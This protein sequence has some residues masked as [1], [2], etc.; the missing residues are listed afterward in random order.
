MK[1][2]DIIRDEMIKKNSH[3]SQDRRRN[4]RIPLRLPLI[5]EGVN[6]E[7]LP[8]REET[9]TENVSVSGACIRTKQRLG[10]GSQLKISAVK[11]PFRSKAVVRTIWADEI[12][13]VM[14]IGVEFLDPNENWILK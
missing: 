7:G 6:I 10:S 13:G 3:D 2:M 12:D 9:E 11:F 8:F 4:V 14:K 5:I 1:C